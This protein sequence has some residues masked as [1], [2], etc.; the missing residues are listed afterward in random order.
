M[1]EAYETNANMRQTFYRI[2]GIT[3]VEIWDTDEGYCPALCDSGGGWR[4]DR[5][6]GTPGHVIAWARRYCPE[7]DVIG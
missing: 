5:E 1:I 7:L 2:N 3:H 6:F 4:E